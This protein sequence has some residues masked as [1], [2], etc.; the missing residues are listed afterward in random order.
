MHHISGT[1]TKSR[2]KP[3]YLRS[4]LTVFCDPAPCSEKSSAKEVLAILPSYLDQAAKDF[5]STSPTDTTAPTNPATAAA[6]PTY[7]FSI[8]KV[9]VQGIVVALVGLAP[10]EPAAAAGTDA[11]GGDKDS[12]ATTTAAAAGEAG[13]PVAA[14]PPAR[15]LSSFLLTAAIHQL[16]QDVEKR[17]RS[18]FS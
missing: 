6:T 10:A 17:T 14:A 8:A 15:V 13:A 3:G 18:K 9:G 5:A 4:S 16:V 7:Q 11:Q 12:A 1:S 2:I